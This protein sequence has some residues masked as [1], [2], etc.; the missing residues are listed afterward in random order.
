MVGFGGIKEIYESDVDIGQVVQQYKNQVV[1]VTGNIFE[2]YVMQDGY[3]FRGKQLCILVDS[4]RENV[5]RELHSGGLVEHF[6]IDKTIA[7]VVEKYYWPKM[8]RDI[9][10][11]VSHCKVC[12]MAKGN[13]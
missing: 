8:R 13:A 1:G 5:L 7:L 4:M 6:G 9:T 2:E 3:F 11:F 10:K 12:Q